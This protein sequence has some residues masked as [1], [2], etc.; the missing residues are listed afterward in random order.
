VKSEPGATAPS[1]V[2]ILL[3]YQ[4]DVV[5]LARLLDCAEASNNFL[6]ENT[7]KFHGSASFGE[8][9]G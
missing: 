3:S 6:D 8:G 5:P 7:T 4:S 1:K 2:L 9:D